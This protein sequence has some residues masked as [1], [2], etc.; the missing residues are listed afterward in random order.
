MAANG[1]FGSAELLDVLGYAA[2]FS[3]ASGGFGV[4]VFD[5][6]RFSQNDL[7]APRCLIPRF[8][9]VITNGRKHY[10]THSSWLRLNQA[11]I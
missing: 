7:V 3:V 9:G 4:S 10:G 5:L 8:D 6:F 2:C 1:S 11:R